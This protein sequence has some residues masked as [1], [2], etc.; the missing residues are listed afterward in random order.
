MA[1][2]KKLRPDVNEIAHRVMME[3]T[4]Q[5]PRTLPPGARSEEEKNPEAVARGSKG[6]QKG[7]EARRKTLGEDRRKEIARKAATSRWTLTPDEGESG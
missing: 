3:A 6:G 2:K 1:Q 5:A 7:G 4:G